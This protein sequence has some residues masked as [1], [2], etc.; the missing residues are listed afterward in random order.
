MYTHTRCVCICVY[1]GYWYYVCT[2]VN[3]HTEV[4]RVTK[5]LTR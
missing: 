1:D 5:V 3:T 4:G 2:Y